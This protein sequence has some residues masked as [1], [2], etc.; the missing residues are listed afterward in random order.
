MWRSWRTSSAGV[1]S[2]TQL[3][4]FRRV[5]E[6]TLAWL[7]RSRRLTIRCDRLEAIHQALLDLGCALICLNA[8]RWPT[9]GV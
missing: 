8:L 1:E 4:R 7:A 2:R 5:A 6:R 3:G 9:V